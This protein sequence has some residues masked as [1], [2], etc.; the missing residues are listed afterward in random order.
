MTKTDALTY[1]GSVSATAKAI[2]ISDAAVSQWPERIPLL[3]Q[4]QIAAVTQGRLQV[5][6]DAHLAPS[7]PV[8]QT[9]AGA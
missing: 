1:F 7:E 9:A 2:G 6:A 3:R 5:D 8:Q 4:Y